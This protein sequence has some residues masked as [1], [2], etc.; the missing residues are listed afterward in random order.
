MLLEGIVGVFAV[1][2]GGGGGSGIIQTRRRTGGGAGVGGHGA[3]GDI[4]R[5]FL[6]KDIIAMMMVMVAVVVVVSCACMDNHLLFLRHIQ[7]QP[8]W[9][10]GKALHSLH[11]YLWEAGERNNM[12]F[13]VEEKLYSHSRISLLFSIHRIS[14]A[15]NRRNAAGGRI[16]ERID[17]LPA[18]ALDPKVSIATSGYLGVSI[19]PHRSRRP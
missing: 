6:T 13:F 17:I 2:V 10:S 11:S 15:R 8:A 9:R 19:S 7:V 18:T 16:Q 4:S 14:N 12:F 1:V 5:M 3:A